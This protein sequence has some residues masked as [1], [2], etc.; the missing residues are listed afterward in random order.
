MKI[1]LKVTSSGL[2]PMYDS[3]HEEKKK[4]KIGSEVLAEIRVPRNLEHHKK[5]FA[6]LRLVM[7][8]MPETLSERYTSTERL[9]DEIKFQ[10][11]YFEEH[12]TLSGR[13]TYKPKSI[14]FDTMNQTDFEAFYNKAL[15]VVLKWF[16]TGN[17]KEEIIDEIINYM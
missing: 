13:V 1:Y 4:L 12:I 6:L 7:D 10:C 8:N 15:D 17:T 3:D 16:L 9:L 14:A 11:G 5:F 2:V